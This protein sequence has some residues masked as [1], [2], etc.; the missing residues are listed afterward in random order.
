MSL[1]NPWSVGDTISV[2]IT[3]LVYRQPTADSTEESLALIEYT[4][5]NDQKWHVQMEKL[6]Y[7]DSPSLYWA[8]DDALEYQ[9]GPEQLADGSY[10]RMMWSESFRPTTWDYYD[11]LPSLAGLID[12]PDPL[13]PGAWDWNAYLKCLAIGYNAA[14]Y[15]AAAA[16]LFSLVA[17]PICFGGACAA[18]MLGVT[19]GC[20]LGQWL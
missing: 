7:G 2:E 14:C 5:Y 16:C 3:M 18:G 20:V 19:I 12:P 11:N 6:F 4:S 8:E 9:I 10:G 15:S 1:N 13:D 17:W